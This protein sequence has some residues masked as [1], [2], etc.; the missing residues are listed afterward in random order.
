MEKMTDFEKAFFDGLGSLKFESTG[1]CCGCPECRDNHSIEDEATDRELWENGSIEDEGHFS[2]EPCE[3]CGSHL[4]GDRYAAHA[5]DKDD[6]I[7][8]FDVCVDCVMY[9]ANGDL[10]ENW[11]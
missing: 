11:E 2:W 3:L 5:V 6:E 7:V 4:G 10:P 1:F 8:H 9:M